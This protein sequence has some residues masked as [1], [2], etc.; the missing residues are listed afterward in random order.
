MLEHKSC[1]LWCEEGVVG[2]SVVSR[3]RVILLLSVIRQ[4]Y[5]DLLI[6]ITLSERLD[7]DFENA[8]ASPFGAA[9]KLLVVAVTGIKLAGLW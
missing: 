8:G 1:P 6:V 2:A 7:R 3:R 4:K 5:C 9:K